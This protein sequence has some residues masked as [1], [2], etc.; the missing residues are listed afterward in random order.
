M[1]LIHRVFE[2]IKD[3]RRLS[4]FG[5]AKRMRRGV[6]GALVDAVILQPNVSGFGFDLK[7]LFTGIKGN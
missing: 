2:D 5:A 3:E 6:A 1:Q 4:E 7:T